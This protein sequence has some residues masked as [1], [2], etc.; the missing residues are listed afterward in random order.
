MR[1]RRSDGMKN[2]D[3]VIQ[4]QMSITFSNADFPF[5]GFGYQLSFE[6]EKQHVRLKAW[7]Q[8]RKGNY[9]I[10]ASTLVLRTVI[11]QL[12]VTTQVSSQQNQ[13]CPLTYSA[14]HVST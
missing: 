3:L 1:R 13:F 14:T 9:D 5:S 11:N 7:R 4:V 6:Q 12:D 8:T 2:T 10:L